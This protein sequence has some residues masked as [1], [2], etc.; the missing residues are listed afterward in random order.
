MLSIVP[1]SFVST[2]SYPGFWQLV[3]GLASSTSDWLFKRQG[4][5][6]FAACISWI[7]FLPGEL[8]VNGSSV[9]LT[10]TENDDIYM[11]I[12]SMF[13]ASVPVT[14]TRQRSITIRSLPAK[15]CY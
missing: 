7:K 3:P 12:S 1:V 14:V 11:S 10:E 15:V 5:L 13:C 4:S 9:Y 8:H 2:P 6:S